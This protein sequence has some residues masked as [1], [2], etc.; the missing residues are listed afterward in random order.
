[1]VEIKRNWQDPFSTNERIEYPSILA[2]SN[3][4]IQCGTDATGCPL[5]IFFDGKLHRIHL[6]LC[7]AKFY[8]SNSDRAEYEGLTKE[9]LE[10]Y[11][12]KNEIAE[13]K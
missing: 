9:F 4:C 7:K 8:L 1:M 2:E 11:V 5:T 6:G 10:D 3:N 13:T 12:K